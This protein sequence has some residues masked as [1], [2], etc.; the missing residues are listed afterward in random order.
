MSKKTEKVLTAK[1]AQKAVAKRD[2]DLNEYTKIEESAAEVLAKYNGYVQLNGISQLSEPLAQVFAKHKGGLSLSG[3]STL[4][5]EIA[6]LLSN[7]RGSIEL[8]GLKNL[9]KESAR[10]LTLCPQ[11]LYLN[12]LADISDELLAILT[13]HKEVLGLIA[14]NKLSLENAKLF[15][16]H[17]GGGLFLGDFKRLSPDIAR[18]LARHSGHL[19]LGI[20]DISDEVIDIFSAREEGAYISNLYDIDEVA[21]ADYSDD[22]EFIVSLSFEYCEVKYNGFRIMKKGEIRSLVAALS[23][24]A[25]IGTPNMPGEWYEEFDISLLKDCFGIHSPWPSYIQAMRKVFFGEESVGETSL[26]DSVLEHASSIDEG[27]KEDS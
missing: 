21:K 2:S 10:H 26:F 15:S 4:S 11:A 19:S 27:Q 8:N 16:E 5:D 23:T 7:R 6:S 24:G 18:V 12:G 20:E 17:Q 14:F 22:R 3:I 1:I 9:S 13:K 25:K